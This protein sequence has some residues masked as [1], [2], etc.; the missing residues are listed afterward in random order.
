MN[1][2]RPVEKLEQRKWE[3]EV[4]GYQ[5]E[6]LYIISPNFDTLTLEDRDKIGF[7]IA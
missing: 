1:V 6:F 4:Y 5:N 3:N 7:L 2:Q